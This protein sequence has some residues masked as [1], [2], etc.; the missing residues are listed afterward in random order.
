MKLKTFLAITLLFCLFN[1]YATDDKNKVQAILKSATVYRAGAELVHNAKASI[2]QGNTELIIENISSYVDVNS[3]QINCPANITIMGVA[4]SNNYLQ[5]ETYSVVIK[6]LQ[7]SVEKLSS[8]I[9]AINTNIET[10]TDLINV[11]KIN[12]QVKGEQTGMSVAELAKLMDYYKLKSTELK[13]ELT[14]LQN[15]KQKL[16]AVVTKLNN[17]INE[18]EKKNIKTGGNIILQLNNAIAGTYEFT[19]SYITQNAYW[20]PYYDIKADDIKSPMKITYKAKIVQTTGIDWQK[21][22]LSL[23]TSTP[24][25]Y[26]NAP[27]LKAWFLAYINP[28]SVMNNQLSAMNSIQSLQGKVAGLTIG[29]TNLSEVVVTGYGTRRELDENSQF[30]EKLPP[31]YIVNGA[32][33]LESDYK[34]INPKAIKD[35]N[36]LKDKNATSLYGSRAINGAVIVTLKYGLDE[37]VTTTQNELDVSYDIELP[38]DVPTNGKEQIATIKEEKINAFYKYY[39]VPKLD[40][41]AFLL[42]EI[43]DWGKLNLLPGEANIIFEGTYIGKTF[44]DPANTSDTLNLTMG[45]DKRVVIKREKLMDYS[46]VKFLG[47][48]KLQTIT[49]NITVKNNK[50]DAIDLLLKD[51]YP[52]STNKEIEVNVEESSNATN[53][54]D[55]GVLTW[56]LHLAPG[57]S[58]KVQISYSVK[59]PKGKTLNLN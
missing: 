58:K 57:E 20:T 22:K 13:N 53:N 12:N 10:T 54:E 8:Q 17:Q 51:Q 50:K 29:N 28:V 37:F 40:K 2:P 48:N 3:I 30:A 36:V 24:T 41:D 25:Q 59:Y 23:S 5:P 47:T 6:K 56:K 33:M 34:K 44:I 35:I 46:S 21:V 38:Y 26:G 31:L 42:A 16:D 55:I 9:Q 7:D 27:I 43:T 1:A 15:K 39:A 32:E 4:F 19:I 14:L 45:K 18:E 52:I 49:Y 11:L